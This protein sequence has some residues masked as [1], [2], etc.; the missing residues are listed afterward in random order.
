MPGKLYEV[1]N[2][3]AAIAC[4][5]NN[6]HKV[7]GEIYRLHD[8]EKLLYLLDDYEE[9]T[10]R[11]PVPHEY[12]RCEIFVTL[13]DN[14]TLLAWA[15]LYNWPV[16]G[17]VNI[18]CGDYRPYLQD[19]PSQSRLNTPQTKVIALCKPSNLNKP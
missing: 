18:I 3:P 8:A 5:D 9:C 14:T 19:Q 7:H 2:Y 13:P 17:L 15:Y 10:D 11:F 4:P 16:T 12:S 6:S 1:Q